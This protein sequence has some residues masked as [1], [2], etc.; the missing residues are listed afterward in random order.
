[1]LPKIPHG[2]S[3]CLIAAIPVEHL[4]HQYQ[5]F[6]VLRCPASH[7]FPLVGT[8]VHSGKV[9]ALLTLTAPK[10]KAVRLRAIRMESSS[11]GVSVLM[12]NLPDDGRVQAQAVLD[13]SWRRWAVQVYYRR[14]YSHEKPFRSLGNTATGV[15]WIGVWFPQSSGLLSSENKML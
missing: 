3:C 14:V 5:G 15:N 13:L 11:G 7:T 9:E 12:T 10:A 8:F 4:R 1:M 6:W 2:G